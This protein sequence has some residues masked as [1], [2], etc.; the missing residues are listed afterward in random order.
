M[1]QPQ[2]SLSFWNEGECS[3]A[4]ALTA[5]GVNAASAFVT[6]VLLTSSDYGW[7]DKRQILESR[8]RSAGKNCEGELV[9]HRP[10]KLSM[11]DLI[12]VR[13]IDDSLKRF[14]DALD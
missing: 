6:F 1:Q 13:R 8:H 9:Q 3:R 11:N 14:I 12:C 10:T 5:S 7:S 4:F 2:T